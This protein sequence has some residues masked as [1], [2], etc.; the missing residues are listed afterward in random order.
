MPASTVPRTLPA[1]L[2]VVLVA[3]T[4]VPARAQGPAAVRAKRASAFRVADGAIHMDGRLDEPSWEQAPPMLDFVQKEPVE[5][6][7]PTESMDVRVVYD[8]SALY[9]GARMHKRPGS[10]IQA[11][12]GRRDRPEQ[13]E[14]LQI[15][16]DTFHDRRTAYVFGVT[17]AGVRIDRF[18][19][20]D[21]ETTFDEGY[22]PVWRARTHVTE[23][24]WTAEL[25]VPFS[26]LRFTGSSDQ[27]W[28]LNIHR[29]I[30]ELNEDDY[31]VPIPRTVTAW[32]SRF[33]ELGGIRGV[34]A[35]Q[36][37]EL[38]P[39]MA[40]ASAIKAQPDPANPFAG[41]GSRQG[42]VGADVKVG[43]GSNLTLD[44]TINPDFGQVEADPAEVN[45]SGVETFF[46]ERRPFFTEGAGLL[47]LGAVG[48]FFYSRRIG[49]PPLSSASGDFVNAPAAS[50][51][52]GAAKLTG[53][54]SS[55]LS[56][57]ALGAVTGAEQAQVFMRATSLTSRVPV[58]PQT[59]YAV[60]RVQQEFGRNKSTFSGMAT[61][62]HRSLEPGTTL[63]A[64][65]PRNAF[66]AAGDS[67]LRF[68]G[69]EYVVTS[70]LGMSLL[71]GDANALARVQRASAHFAQR[72]DRDYALYDPTRT[73][74]SGL[75]AGGSLQRQGGRH[76]IWTVQHDNES[77]NLDLNDLGRLGSADGLQV[78]GDVRYRET[79]PGGIFRSYFV[80]TRQSN[81][82][83]YGGEHVTKGSQ[84]YATQV[85]R[86]FWTTQ[87]N[88]TRNRRRVDARLT[89]GG[90]LMEVPGGWTANLQL[91]NR[92]A[93][94][95]S[96]TTQLQ[97]AGDEDGGMTRQ[98]DAT[99]ALRPGPQWQF[100]VAP[101]FLRQV[102]T[103]QYVTSVAGGGDFTYGRRYVF[104]RIDRSTY[105]TQFRLTYTFKP[106]L[107]LDVYA[108][109][110]AASG[111]YTN[112][113]ELASAGTRV[114]R[115]YG[116]AEG[117]S[118]ARQGDGSLL[119]TDGAASFRLANNDF[120]VRSLRSNVVLR[121]EYRPGSVLYLVWQQ[122]RSVREAVGDRIGF[123]DPFR[124][125]RERGDHYFVVKT[126]FWLPRSGVRRPVAVA[127]TGSETSATAEQ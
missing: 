85:W 63:Q 126:S 33:G 54:T 22:D 111:H 89:R 90:P 100:S 5:G 80:G 13:A 70:Y 118:V 73:S 37:L 44:A 99:L 123:G 116:T 25:W 119:V 59:S 74:L 125:L 9:I 53:R 27:V 34:Q 87:I 109:P 91:R 61:M 67:V 81:E 24:G 7:P 43:V 18:H 10:P 106:D 114:R 41:A 113:G 17:A 39:Y 127:S 1:I 40:A 3:L 120:N 62:L 14:N 107:N 108:E 121:W 68:R 32:A 88:Y 57:G 36:R 2:I 112:V 105:A 64:L 4:A 20:D 115:T 82:W 95:T 49:G 6:A 92:S 84:V 23:Q 42:R 76:W 12:M 60:A 8:S 93:S 117:T 103:Q 56:I 11:P 31:W 16:L 38:L 15:A 71:T 51:I 45:L 94:Q 35:S 28:G 104:G 79:V 55:G 83:T 101:S 75:K 102:D 29:Y 78:I 72:P 50:T 122:N 77:P 48:N 69:G 46:D 66:A 110:F 19:R 58:T 96:W 98:F 65:L 47:N 124:S 86:N 97:L 52:L 30:P 21:N 26:Q